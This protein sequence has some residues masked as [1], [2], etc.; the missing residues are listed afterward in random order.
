[1]GVVRGDE[2]SVINGG[3]AS[4][5]ESSVQEMDDG[6]SCTTTQCT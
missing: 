2:E 5:Q 6:F 3:R 1:M 4:V